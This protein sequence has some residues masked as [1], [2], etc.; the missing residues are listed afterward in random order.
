MHDFEKWWLRDVYVT[1][2]DDI[3][4]VTE[5]KGQDE[6]ADMCTVDVCISHDDDLVIAQLLIV[7]SLPDAHAE[8]DDEILELF[9]GEDLVQVRTLS[10]QNLSA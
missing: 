7:D 5:E 2:C 3:W 4:K 10:I 9:E 6:R 8:C 1:L